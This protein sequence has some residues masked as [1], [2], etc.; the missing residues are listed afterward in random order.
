MVL[1]AYRGH[2]K[3]VHCA[4]FEFVRP[5]SGRNVIELSEQ[6]FWTQEVKLFDSRRV[7]KTFINMLE[8]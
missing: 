2:I 6:S 5:Q 3:D 8:Y 4:N 7:Q 1:M